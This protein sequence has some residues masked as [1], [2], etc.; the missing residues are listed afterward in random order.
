[1]LDKLYKYRCW[2]NKYHTRIL[3]HNEIFFSSVSSF[4]DPFDSMIPVKYELGTEKQ[5]FDLYVYHIKQDRP[6]LSPSNQISIA[7]NYIQNGKFWNIEVIKQNRKYEEQKRLKEYGVF[8]LCKSNENI[9]MWSHYS[10]F[11]KG[12]CVGF[13]IPNFQKFK[14]KIGLKE[15]MLFN[16]VSSSNKCNSQKYVER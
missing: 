13:N 6:D 4:N 3:T 12:F 14:K 2:S 15:K 7:E 9:V 5:I 16:L 1:M 10:D 8:S 11:H